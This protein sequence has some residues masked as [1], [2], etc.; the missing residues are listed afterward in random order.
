MDHPIFPIKNLIHSLLLAFFALFCAE[1]QATWQRCRTKHYLILAQ[2][3]PNLTYQIAQLMEKIF[4]Q[5]QRNFQAAF[6]KKI[7]GP[8][9]L[10]IFQSKTSLQQYLRSIRAPTQWIGAYLRQQRELVI[11][12]NLPLHQLR[13]LLLHE[14]LHQFLES[15]I[16]HLP[17]W[18]NEGL[19][20]YFGSALVIRGKFKFG[21]PNLEH[22]A[23]L[24]KHRQTLPPIA[25]VMMA[26][27]PTFHR[28]QKEAIHYAQSWLLLHYLITKKSSLLHRLF[29]LLYHRQP[30]S[31]P[32]LFGS[33][34][35]L[36][37]ALERHL[38]HLLKTSGQLD[39]ERSQRLASKGK[40]PSAIA[41]LGSCL[42]KN[43]Y[44]IPARHQRGVL[45]F[46]QSKPRQAIQELSFVIQMGYHWP[47][48]FY[49][50]ARS[51]L[52]LRKRKKA[53]QDLLFAQKL[54]PQ[55]PRIQKEL[56]KL[57]HG[58]VQ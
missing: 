16:P 13:S 31:Y 37:K 57:R 8:F 15:Y 35:R 40:I 20:E 42:L 54:A 7:Q 3:P 52:L 24:N 6:K 25:Q 48:T 44:H 26:D 36:Q 55:N 19:A 4:A 12:G 43:P 39:F 49:Y 30:I 23:L 58:F 5:Y 9:L 51:Y 29:R 38:Q 27:H 41:A 47:A 10:R 22:L 34:Q 28:P 45:Y 14:G 53:Y 46:Y 11:Y 56:K 2:T 17:I 18:L 32:Q 50:R 1:A 33:A 21:L